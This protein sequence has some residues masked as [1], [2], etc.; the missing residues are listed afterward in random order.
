MR[1]YEDIL[2]LATEIGVQPDFV[3]GWSWILFLLTGYFWHLYIKF[4]RYLGIRFGRWVRR[5]LQRKNEP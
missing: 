3:I 5:K 1:I 2:R 4:C